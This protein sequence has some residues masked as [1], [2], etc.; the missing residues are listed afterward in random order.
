[1]TINL[2]KWRLMLLT[3]PIT[4][5]VV[6][7]KIGIVQWLHF[8]GL[9]SFS[10]TGLVF[11]GGIFLVGF[12]LAG[13]L[14]DY[15]ES[16]KIPAEMASTIES[17]YDTVVL[18]YGFNPNFDLLAQKNQIYEVTRSIIA[19]F[20]HQESEE[21]VY[22]KIDEITSVALWVEKTRMGSTTS[23]VKREQT[24]LRKLFAR[25]TVI[26]RTNFISTGYAFLEVMTLLIIGL[27]MIT[28]FENVIISIILVG[29]I[30]QIYVYMV[31]LIKDIDHPFEYP[32]DGKIRA[33][34]ID[35][36]PLIEYEQRAKRNLV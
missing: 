34:D 28:R 27:L 9:V 1:M 4:A 7:L 30:T 23:W 26:K 29:F 18:A 5:V 19:Y 22:K 24:N 33:A 10:E 31:S 8:D 3:F 17:I 2:V 25:A 14:A 36:F 20:T 11:T 6:F 35:L 12:M 16:E 13:T 15:K 21:V 32:L